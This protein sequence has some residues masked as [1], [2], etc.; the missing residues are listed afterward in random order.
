MTTTNPEA[1][2]KKLIS[3]PGDVTF[4][5]EVLAW[6]DAAVPAIVGALATNQ[7]VP[8]M[9]ALLAILR[10]DDPL[11][12]L[13]PLVERTDGSVAPAALGALARVRDTRVL[14]ILTAVLPDIAAITAIGDHGD[15]SGVDVLREL[16]EPIVGADGSRMPAS[17]ALSSDWMLSELDLAVAVAIA[18]AKLGD[19]SLAPLVVHLASLTDLD[20]PERG[21]TL[22][23]SAMIALSYVTAPGVAG[24]LR[25]ALSDPNEDV[26]SEALRSSLYLGRVS[27]GEGFIELIRRDTPLAGIAL[28]YL[29]AWAGE[30]PT[31]NVF[32][33]VDAESLDHWWRGASA[34]FK[35]GVCYRAG[36]PID[37]GALVAQLADD[38]LHL[39][40]E[41]GIHTGA[42]CF[43][44][45]LGGNPVSNTERRA[46]ESWWRCDAVKFWPGKLHRWGRTFE[47]SAVD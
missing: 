44:S 3:D 35:P 5:D 15:A 12:T 6:G 45:D 8:T 33:R 39:R 40:D 28:W 7:S 37:I 26:I 47:P 17:D 27:E 23:V 36:V 9:S 32:K 38:P 34:R 29:Q 25:K 2:I 13:Q 16:V 4:C 41:L 42:P 20:D 14:P 30:H 24:A 1:A 18:M 46:V 10:L 31:G 19:Q 22:R 11:A 43:H 21:A